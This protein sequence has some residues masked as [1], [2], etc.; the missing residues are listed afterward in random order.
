MNPPFAD[1]DKHLLKA[2][3]MQKNGGSIICLLN[4]E[5]IRNPY[6]LTRKVLVDKLQEL[7]ADIQYIDDAFSSDAERKAD[8]DVAI[9]RIHIEYEPEESTIWEQ[10]KK[11]VMEEEIP[12]AE[13][14]ALVAGDYIEQAIQ[15]Y[16]TEVAATMKLVREY[17]ALV[18]YMTR[19]L[20]P[21]DSFGKTPILTLTVGDDSYLFGFDHNKYLRTVRLKYWT[22]LFTN[23]QFTSRLTSKL[24]ERFRDNVNR[25][26]D[27]EFSAFNIKQIMVE[28][29]ASMIDGVK[30]AIMDLF[31]KLTAEHTWYPE[32]TK[33]IHYFNGWKT[34]KAHKIGNKCIIPTSGMFSSY[35]W[36]KEAFNK[37]TAYSVINDI[38]KAFDYLNADLEE[39][40]YD[41]NAR[42]SWAHDYGRTRNIELKYFKIDLFKKG[43][44]HIKFYPES[45]KLVERLNIYAAQERKWLPPSY[46]QKTYSNLQQE[47]KAVVDSF[48]GDG[49]DG[50]GQAAYTEILSQ[51]AYYLADPTQAV[52]ALAG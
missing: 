41:L 38:E 24:R 21:S 6:T 44:M 47:E 28:M 7:N 23:E 14:H 32:C 43:T 10:M 31:D 48:H 40:G 34:N 9:V 8:V 50:S 45:M 52:P 22:A 26:A 36:E 37:S 30:K 46:G 33:N 11:A 1:G 3:E 35:S 18:P 27:Y 2:I 25:M 13:I 17:K 19:T 42:L 51:S 29:N 49:T 5:T 15:L 16:N 4:A 12:D 39:S 20:N